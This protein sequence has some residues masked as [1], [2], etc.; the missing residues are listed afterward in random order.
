[1]KPASFVACATVINKA[2]PVF[3]NL[4]AAQERVDLTVQQRH[5]LFT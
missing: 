1:M 3:P 5:H 2:L 4:R